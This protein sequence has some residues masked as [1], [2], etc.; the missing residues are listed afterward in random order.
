MSPYSALQLAEAF[1]RTGELADALEALNSHLDTQ[2][3][4][5]EALRLR[6][7]VLMRLPGADYARAAMADLNAVSDKSEDDYVQ[8]SVI[9]QLGLGD[10]GQA[11]TAT[12]QAHGL[13]LDDERITERLLMLYEQVGEI[14][15]AQKLISELPESW[16]WLQL[17]GD[18]ALRTHQA[19]TAIE[20]YNKALVLLESK[21]DTVGNPIAQNIAGMIVGS[22][23]NAYLEADQFANAEADYR[24][25]AEAFPKD[26]SYALMV[27]ITLALQGK[28]DE[29]VSLCK[30]VLRDEPSLVEMLREKVGVYPALK[31]LMGRLGM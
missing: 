30:S 3:D 26:L 21:M 12:E 17:A 13:A 27:G 9:W 6:A 4:D 7:S 28:A 19:E 25:A 18:L 15:K 31:A 20:H 14:E 5:Q 22:R 23:A 10:W 16:R 8:E 29:A 24:A 2:P 11:V 1:I